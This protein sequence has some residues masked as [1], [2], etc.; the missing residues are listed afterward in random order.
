MPTEGDSVGTISAVI[1]TYNRL[2]LLKEC[3]AAVRSQSRSPDEIIVVNNGGT[4]ST[5]EWL[6][7][8]DDLIVVNQGNSGGSGGYYTGFQTA[9]DRGYDWIW[10][11]ICCFCGFD[12]AVGEKSRKIQHLLT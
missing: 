5:E 4:D 12:E 10:S 2:A 9:Y 11:F 3:V 1:D 8:Q 7:E 6:A